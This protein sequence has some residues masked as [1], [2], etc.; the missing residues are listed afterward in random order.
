VVAVV[1]QLEL[2]AQDLQDLPVHQVAQVVVAQV[3]SATV[4]L[5]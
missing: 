4:L 2:L 1:E 5:M 3:L